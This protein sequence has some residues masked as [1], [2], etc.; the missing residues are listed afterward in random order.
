MP[1]LHSHQFLWVL[2]SPVTTVV[3]SAGSLGLLT[4]HTSWAKLPSVR[5]RY[6]FPAV[7][8]GRS[9]PSQ[10]RTICAPPA[11]AWPLAPGIWARY[12]GA[13]GSVTSTTDVPLH[14]ALPVS[15]LDRCP[16]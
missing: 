6:V 16:P 2:A 9:A 4:S 13:R 11:S 1:V 7:P 5:S 8:R 14:S 3:S 10:T 12:R 15:G